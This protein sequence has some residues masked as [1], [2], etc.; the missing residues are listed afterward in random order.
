[1][2]TPDR[3]VGLLAD[4]GRMKVLA[5][6]AL[7]AEDDK[8][9]VAASGM[10]PKDVVIARQRLTEA[11]LLAADGRI[12]FDTLRALA[13]EHSQAVPVDQ[14]TPRELGAFVRHGRLLGMP[15]QHAKRFQ[16]LS[17]ITVTTFEEDELYSEAEVNALLQ[18]WCEGGP[19]DH[20]TVRR[21]LIDNRLLVRGDGNYQ[22]PSL[23][24]GPEPNLGETY[25]RAMGLS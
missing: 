7:G 16:L 6:I 2:L 23:D 20:V 12:D 13:K 3:L 14:S 24:S 8:A 18:R 25:V 21:Y 1:M 19:V 5:A 22:R 10:G 4:A 17:L 15:V 9:I 11:G